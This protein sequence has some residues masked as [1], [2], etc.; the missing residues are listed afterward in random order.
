MAGQ[1]VNPS[2]AV[3]GPQIGVDE[4]V[5][6]AA[7]DIERGGPLRQL[8]ERIPG[9]VRLVVFV[10]AAAS[11]PV[12]T[13]NGY[14]LRVGTDTL[15]YAMLALGLN[16]AVGWAGLLDLGYIAFF[17]FGAYGYA[18]LA[19]PKFGV[20]WPAWGVLPVV[21]VTTAILG[22]VVGLPSRRLVGDYLAI[23]TLFFGQLFLTVTTNGER[24]SV[25]GLTRPYDVT[26]GPNGIAN[27][28]PF[29]VFGHHLIQVRAYFWVALITFVVAISALYFL[30]ESR[31]GRAW[32]ALRE[33][34]LAAELLSIPVNRLKLAAF[35]LGAAVAGLTGTIFAAL[36]T[37][38]FSNTFDVSLLILIYAMVILG[39]SGSLAGVVL[40]A[41]VIN[42]SLETLRTPDH[43]SWI[44]YG[45]ILLTLLAKMRPWREL[46]LFLGG[47]VG[48]GFAA[49]AI[50]AAT[51]ARGT[52][53]VVGEAGWVGHALKHWVVLP[54]NPAQIGNYA[55]VA[56]IAAIIGVSMLKGRWRRLAL[57][58]TLYLAA[59]VWENALVMQPSITRFILLGALLV[60]LMNARPEGILGTPRVEIV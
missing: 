26:G 29:R 25:L 49:H 46:G 36:N 53:G 22:L 33:D 54:A 6:R 18:V 10:A 3:A 30:N 39:G 2:E 41:I 27:I 50:V 12:I 55:Y 32:R 17:G 43:A 60:A 52:K 9:A 44:F 8:F 37:G 15:I 40:G 20:H 1:P 28:D 57:V 42:V 19:S 45:L 13:S 56:L 34:P 59:F 21:T 24:I 58:P 35:S 14:V 47:L 5:A 51:W 48:F 4:W 23:V 31:T 7:E 16:V 11:I 38:V